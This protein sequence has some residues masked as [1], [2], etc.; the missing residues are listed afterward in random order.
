MNRV[1]NGSEDA[2]RELLDQ[3]GEHI[4]RVI[5]RRLHHRMRSQFDSQDFAQAVW[6]SFFARRDELSRFESPDDLLAFLQAVAGNK[7]IDECRR[8]LQSTKYDVG[9]E[10]AIE[11]RFPS[12]DESS[13]PASDK[14]P[15]EI[16]SHQEQVDRV[17]NEMPSHYQRLMEMRIGGATFTEIAQTMGLNERAV[18]RVFKRLGPRVL[19]RLGRPPKDDNSN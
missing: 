9:R 12:G 18:R 3:Y 13:L 10:L 15:S 1:K 8:R 7:I 17:F 19:K 14:T 5:R 2:I 11:E 4:F 16:V 6:A